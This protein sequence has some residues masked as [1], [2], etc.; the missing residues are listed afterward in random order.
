[1]S[2]RNTKVQ[3]IAAVIIHEVNAL[4]VLFLHV[5]RSKSMLL[6]RLFISINRSPR[7]YTQF[8]FVQVGAIGISA[9]CVLY[10][11][12]SLVPFELNMRF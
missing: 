5:K 6:L 1:M 10:P 8:C 4:T 9:N 3:A 2:G 12:L 7:L 11:Y